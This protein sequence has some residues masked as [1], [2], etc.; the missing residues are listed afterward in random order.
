MTILVSVVVPVY[1]PGRY[2]QP[3][4]DSLERQG[5][6]LGSFETIFVDDGSTDG[7]AA[8]LDAWCAE[9]ENATVV[10]QE[11][12]GWPGQPRNV[13]I[14]S[15]RGEYIQFV[16]QDDWLGDSALRHLHG[17]AKAHR[18]DIVIGKM[19]GIKRGVPE[20]LFRQSVPQV[21]IGKEP[22]QNSQTPHKMFRRAFLDEIGLRFPEGRRRLEDH[23][24]VTSAFLQADIISIYADDDCYFHI[25]RDD[26]GNA[27]FRSYDPAE[28]YAAVDEVLDIVERLRPAGPERQAFLDRW[29]RREL[30]GRL[31]E[32]GVRDLPHRRREAFYREVRRIVRDRYRDL[33]SSSA[34]IW[35]RIGAAVIRVSEVDGFYAADA[36]LSRLTV[37]AWT[38][39]HGIRMRIF[40]RSR[41]LPL[42][43]TVADVTS[44][45]LSPE[46]DAAVQIELGRDAQS[47]IVPGTVTLTTAGGQKHALRRRGDRFSA[48]AV[49]PR[50]GDRVRIGLRVGV[51]DVV[52]AASDERPSAIAFRTSS[53]TKAVR[54]TARRV[55]GP[56]VPKWI[57]RRYRSR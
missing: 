40:E 51:R 52:L 17:Y 28:Y 49:T 48:D 38:D 24:F 57:T 6:P 32:P 31:R 50:P 21:T 22:I 1:N 33:S 4:L 29:L 34:P 12:H 46:L 41:E 9:H 18:S 8:L 44:R 36:A 45:L 5:L 11:N 23:V 2:L 56:Y 3:L 10:H 53:S 26:G 19:V 35:A 14:D 42:A 20:A 43:S 30:V 54:N 25:S 7:T 13:G 55:L 37:H 27:G 47:A 15:A 39:E 16:D